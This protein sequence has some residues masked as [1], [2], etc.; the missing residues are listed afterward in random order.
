MVVGRY[1]RKFGAVQRAGFPSVLQKSAAPT[2]V[3]SQRF[4]EEACEG[5]VQELTS[6]S[7]VTAPN[8]VSVICLWSVLPVS[9]IEASGGTFHTSFPILHPEQQHDSLKPTLPEEPRSLMEKTAHV[10]LGCSDH[11]RPTSVSHQPGRGCTDKPR[12]PRRPLDW[13]FLSESVSNA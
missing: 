5:W 9:W 3:L 10:S 8:M 11:N 1:S 4:P 6:E 13:P 12:S 2:L 7:R